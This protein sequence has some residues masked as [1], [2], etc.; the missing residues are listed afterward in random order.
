MKNMKQILTVIAVLVVGIQAAGQNLDQKAEAFRI[1]VL[2][3]YNS[4]FSSVELTDGN[5]MKI[6]ALVSYT[7]MSKAGKKAIMD[8]L[9]KNWQESLMV[10]QYGTMKEL[11]GWDGNSRE[12][13]LIDS[14]DSDPKPVTAK[15][16][17]SL[18]NSELHPWFFYIGGA[19]RMDSEKNINGALSARV[20]FFLFKDIWDLAATFS[21]LLSG[22]IESDE[23]SLQ[24][25]IGIMSKVYYPIKKYNIS[26]FIGGEA[27]VQLVKDSDPSFTFSPL[28]G[29]SWF[30]GSGSLDM[31]VRVTG[32]KPSFMIG[33]TLVPKFR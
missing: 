33:Y 12:A 21:E 8:N 20:G 5:Q 4:Y 13:I 7:K 1:E 17:E 2:S 3:S 6:G 15:S 11:W 29:L 26:P 27:A 32:G 31:G 10:V 30:V 22:N 25:S 14:W 28:L 23:I 24:T 9:V 19:Q 16:S 18:S